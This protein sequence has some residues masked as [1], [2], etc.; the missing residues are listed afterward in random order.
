MRQEG[1]E[2]RVG[3]GAGPFGQRLRLC[4]VDAV[5]RDDFDTRYRARGARVGIADAAGSENSYPHVNGECRMPNA[6]SND[7]WRME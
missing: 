4:L 5:N 1:V 6:E 3:D 7:E 2:V